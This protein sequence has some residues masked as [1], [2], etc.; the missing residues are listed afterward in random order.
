MDETTTGADAWTRA[1]M[2][3]DNY[4]ERLGPEFWAEPL[5]AV[6]NAAFLIGA[7][8]A[9]REAGRRGR[10]GDW[11]IVAL[12]AILTAIG[13]GSFLFHT[14]AT[15][16]AGTADVLPIM[17]FILTYLYLA[18][19]RVFDLPRWAAALAVAQEPAQVVEI[20][21]YVLTGA[22]PQ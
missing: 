17:I 18:T 22:L 4:C 2:Q 1:M 3:V 8:L 6:S 21:R 11:A 20:L 16:W 10:Q 7:W 5:N 15:G 13:V 19:K 9:W 12:V 14:F